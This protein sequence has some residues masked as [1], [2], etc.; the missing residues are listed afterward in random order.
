MDDMTVVVYSCSPP[1]GLFVDNIAGTSVKINWNVV[2]D[3]LNYSIR[4]RISGSSDPFDWNTTSSNSKWIIDLVPNIE[5][6][7]QVRSNGNCISGNSDWSGLEF[8][9]TISQCDVPSNLHTTNITNEIAKTNWDVAVGADIY[10][11]KYREAGSSD[12]HIWKAAVFNR[13]WLVNLDEDT[14]YEFQSKSVCGSI[15]S[16]WAPLSFFTTSACEKPDTDF[17]TNIGADFVNINWSAVPDFIKFE[18]RY[19]ENFNPVWTT[20]VTT[21]A[22]NKWITGLS[23]A[24]TYDYQIRAKCDYGWTPRTSP[25]LFTTLTSRLLLS[26]G[27]QKPLFRL[28]PNPTRDIITVEFDQLPSEKI[29]IQIQD[30]LGKKVGIFRSDG[31]EDVLNFNIS[32][33]VSGLYTITVFDKSGIFGNRTFIKE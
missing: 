10:L 22:T 5:Y 13:K 6:E 20:I 1:S 7:Y 23:S 21:N 8:F 3:A 18:I 19:K 28:F 27:E 33:L 32:S 11:L 9:T 16:G 31:N 2:P 17:V 12:A 15:K 14:Q 29:S 26:E 25:G 4:M 24:T 30:R